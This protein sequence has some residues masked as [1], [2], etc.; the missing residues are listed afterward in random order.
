FKNLDNKKK[1]FTCYLCEVVDH[2]VADCPLLPLAKALVNRTLKSLDKDVDD[3]RRSQNRLQPQFRSQAKP[4]V[5]THKLSKKAHGY[6]VAEEQET[7][8]SDSNEGT[9]SDETVLLSHELLSKA[10]PSTWPADTGAS[11]H[12]SDQPDLFR[13]YQ[14]IKRRSIQVGGGVMYADYKGTV[15]LV[16]ENGSSTRLKDVLFVPNLGVNLL[17]AR[18]VCQNGLLG[19]F[20][21]NQMFF[22]LNGKKV[23]ECTMK[24]GLYIVTNIASAYKETAFPAS[25]SMGSEVIMSDDS[26]SKELTLENSNPNEQEVIENLSSKEQANYQLWHRRLN[27]LGPEKLR[28]LHKVT[29]LS[30][31][32]K[33]PNDNVMCGVCKLTKMRNYTPKT[34]SQHKNHR[35]ALIQF[36][37]AG[38]FPKSVRGNR[39]FML[40]ID[41]W[42]RRNW[43]ICLNSK[44]QAVK[45]ITLWKAIE[46]GKTK[47]KIAAARTD[48]APE[49]LKAVGEWRNAGNGVEIQRTTIASSHQNGAAER[50]IQTAE[51]GMRAMLED[52]GLPIEFWDYAVEHD[53]YVRNRTDTGPVIDGSVV[54]PEEAYSGVTPSVDHLKIWGSLCYAWINPK[55]IP[56]TQR[57]DKLR[58]VSRAGVFLGFEELTNKHFKVYC[59][60]LGYHQ[61]YSRV[62]VDET[63][64]GSTL[65]LK[66]RGA[67]GPQGTSNIQPDRM[68]RGRPK[69]TEISPF[70]GTLTPQQQQPTSRQVPF[71]INSHLA[72]QQQLE[73]L[74]CNQEIRNLT[75]N[76]KEVIIPPLE[77]EV[78]KDNEEITPTLLKTDAKVES[79]SDE[80]IKSPLHDEKTP[81]VNDEVVPPPINKNSRNSPPK[82]QRRSGDKNILDDT[83]P[84]LPPT[85]TNEAIQI[86]TI[87][88]TTS[89]SINGVQKE[90]IPKSPPKIAK[91]VNKD[92][93]NIKEDINSSIISNTLSPSANPKVSDTTEQLQIPKILSAPSRRYFTRST[94]KR[95]RNDDDEDDGDVDVI[96]KRMH[97]MI[98]AMIA[99]IAIGELHDDLT[100][101]TPNI[102]SAFQSTEIM[103]IP[104]PSSYQKAINDPVHGIAWKNA[105]IE[106]LNSL[107]KNNTWEPVVPPSGSN[108]ITSKWVFT[109]K[110]LSN[111]AI[112]RF[113]ARLVARGF[114][115]IKGED[116]DETFAPTVRMD[117]LRLF[118]AMVA[119]K[120]LKCRHFDIKNA[121]TES[122]LKENI[123]MHPPPGLQIKKGM[124]LKV[125]RSL[126]GLKQAARDWN[127]LMKS[128][129]IKWGFDQS[130]AD[131]CMFLHKQT[132]VMLL[133]YVDDIVGVAKTQKELDWFWGKLSIR[134][135]AKDMGEIEK[136]LG[137]R[138]SRDLKNRTIYLDQEQYLRTVLD[139]FGFK[140]STTSR[141]CH[142]SSDYS[143][144][145]PSTDQDIRI[146]AN[147]YQ[148]VIGS[149]MFAMILTRPDISYALGKLSQHMS[150]PCER[151]GSALKKLMRYLNSTITQKIRY[152]PGGALNHI[153]V[154]SDADWAGDK[155]DRKSTSG[156]V[157]MFYGGPIS[158]G[159]KKQRS[160]AT[161]SCE[162]EYLALAMCAKQGQWIAQICRDLGVGHYIGKYPNCVQMFGDN[163]GSLALVKNP[164]LHERSKHID[165]CYHFIRDLAEQGKLV[166]TYISTKEMVA[167]GMTKPLAKPSFL[168]FKEWMGLVE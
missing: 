71:E 90:I 152:G 63:I 27:H 125:L 108:I 99:Q 76:D 23:I 22:T 70:L 8:D 114:S 139:K 137:M 110:V 73:K 135:N 35:L 116:Y 28:K 113:K 37:I 30:T 160:V 112:E 132:S 62:D 49:L 105:I 11:S 89:T 140:V 130:K 68:P 85:I 67:T 79:K 109:I 18:K 32:I 97:K 127:L 134:F 161:S 84:R 123:F 41:N 165:I 12:M 48:N 58:N 56:R 104:I 60:E 136:I 141:K 143:D 166:V 86:K 154:Y 101:D 128:E 55:T 66:L 15:D 82:E 16:C 150:D 149:L 5:E 88:R 57:K 118:L 78:S 77:S 81:P 1:G 153:A 129:L 53:A 13:T 2:V 93:T 133:V 65:Q 33:V 144:Y 31:P 146:E 156:Y 34:L 164:Q 17:S 122:Q 98:K 157:V 3:N 102:G 69:C 61:R 124:V 40:I 83:I 54:S 72:E 44:D 94:L 119:E 107:M 92:N 142:P 151:H 147:Q 155:A 162:S 148:Q 145:A 50:N 42:S 111:G 38:P 20:D 7:S 52:A 103:G 75:A 138:V 115:Q 51:A 87:P 159:S 47:C 10:T 117:T 59:P 74:Q 64:K 29:T 121:F 106:E 163:Q 91:V 9:D 80:E 19:S 168:K 96:D 25:V 6:A 24:N 4:K 126:Y 14:R 100:E 158:W 43:V 45:A 46:E 95:Q 21:T 167:D 120:E 26:S 39:Y 36:D 131:P